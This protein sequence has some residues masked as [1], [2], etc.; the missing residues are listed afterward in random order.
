MNIDLFAI[1]CTPV[2]RI[3]CRIYPPVFV[4]VEELALDIVAFLQSFLQRA[5]G[6]RFLKSVYNF[7]AKFPDDL[8]SRKAQIFLYR[9]VGQ[10]DLMVFIQHQNVKGKSIQQHLKLNIS[11]HTC[12]HNAFQGIRRINNFR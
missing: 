11:F 12:I 9:F 10:K 6:I 7:G 5:A 1:F 3:N 4:G 2:C 8:V